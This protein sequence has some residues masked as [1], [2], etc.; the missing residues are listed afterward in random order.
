MGVFTMEKKNFTAASVLVAMLIASG[1]F[2][3]A[4]AGEDAST[5]LQ[6]TEAGTLDATEESCQ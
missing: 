3:P 5:G 1:H 6:S 4:N 2:V